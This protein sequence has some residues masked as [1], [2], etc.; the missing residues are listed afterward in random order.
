MARKR[1][2]PATL[3]DELTALPAASRAEVAAQ[4]REHAARAR[5]KTQAKTASDLKGI[6]DLKTGITAHL[7]SKPATEGEEYLRLYLGGKEK[8]RLGRMSKTWE[9]LGKRTRERRDMVSKDIAK[10]ERKMGV[11]KPSETGP[12][13][14]PE[15]AQRQTAPPEHTRRQ[16]KKLSVDY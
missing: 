6:S 13:L 14:K 9:K 2:D 7:R 10:M 8:V 15:G 11:V 5:E 4:I 12:L 3:M 16:W 1:D